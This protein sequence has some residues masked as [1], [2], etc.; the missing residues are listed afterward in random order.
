[1]PTFSDSLHIA[2]VRFVEPAWFADE[3]GRFCET[4]RREWFPQRTWEAMQCNRS[5]N[6]PNVLRGIHYHFHQ[7]DYWQVLA[8]AIEVGLVDLRASSPTFLRSETLRLDAATG[9]GVYI[10]PGVGHGFH[11]AVPSTLL[12][13]VD[14]YY[15]GGDE[16]GVRW[17]DPDLRIGWQC[18][19]PILSARDEA[20]P[21][22][23][24][25]PAANRPT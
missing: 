20:N 23:R 15:D 1:M 2:D 17:N 19:S 12:Y 8:G 3:R 16:W 4:F 22:W 18:P 5:E 9:R 24:D 21:L 13:V 25:V 7:V 11:S 14:Q 10:P 6:R